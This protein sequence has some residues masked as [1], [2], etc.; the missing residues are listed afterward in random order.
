MNKKTNILIVEDE[1]LTAQ[2]LEDILLEINDFNIYKAQSAIEAIDIV[3]KNKI[4][5]AFMDINID[6]SIDGIQC[7]V[8]INKIYSVPVIFI[9]A[10]SDE[11][12]ITDAADTNIYGYIVKPFTKTDISISLKLINKALKNTKKEMDIIYLNDNYQFNKNKNLLSHF[13]NEVILTKREYEIINLFVK[14]LNNHLSYEELI[15]KIWKHKQ[16]SSS[17]VT[18][19][20]FR[21][22]KK[23]PTIGIKNFTSVGYGLFVSDS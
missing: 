12:T 8:K 5:F 20:I 16:V 17:T 7:S 6:G 1:F 15:T 14:N 22:R 10:Y 3:N 2:L 13:G 9:T 21:L 19:T 11:Q 23:V 18:D 4:D